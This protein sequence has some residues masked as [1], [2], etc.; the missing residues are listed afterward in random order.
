MM[1]NCKS[2]QAPFQHISQLEKDCKTNVT[3]K[4]DHKHLQRK[5]NIN[6]HFEMSKKDT[7]NDY[8]YT[9]NKRKRN[10]QRST[11][12]KDFISGFKNMQSALSD[13]TKFTILSKNLPQKL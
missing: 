7:N 5:K 1:L 12:C 10:D 8:K 9:L 2:T 6:K 13:Q 4:L 3:T 11:H